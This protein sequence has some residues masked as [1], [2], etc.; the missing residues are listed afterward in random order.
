MHETCQVR[1]GFSLFA[2]PASL[3]RCG[4]DLNQVNQAG[5]VGSVRNVLLG[6][7]LFFGA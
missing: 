6:S 7:A 4:L 2:G 5:R 3:K 1:K